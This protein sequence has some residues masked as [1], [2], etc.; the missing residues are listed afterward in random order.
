MFAV[1]VIVAKRKTP[2]AKER[3]EKPRIRKVIDLTSIELPTIDAWRRHEFSPAF[4][5][6]GRLKNSLSLWEGRERV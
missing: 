1:E 5:R 2:R 6:R 3:K 4:Q